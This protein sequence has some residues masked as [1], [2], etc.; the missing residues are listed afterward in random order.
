MI[1]VAVIIGLAFNVMA[2][3]IGMESAKCDRAEKICEESRAL[4]EVLL[5]KL[6]EIP[7]EECSWYI[8]TIDSER[9]LTNLFYNEYIKE[10]E[11]HS[12]CE[13][14]TWEE[15]DR[16]AQMSA[17]G[18]NHT[19]SNDGSNVQIKFSQPV[20]IVSNSHFGRIECSGS[21]KPTFSCNNTLIITDTF[22]QSD[23]RV[24]DVVYYKSS[25]D[26]SD[27]Y[28]DVEYVVHRVIGIQGS[29]Y[30][31]RGDV[32]GMEEIVPYLSIKYKVLG[33]IY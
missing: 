17:T 7:K 18:I 8:K 1:V 27:I 4:D 3:L 6:N 33:V 25:I 24:G 9:N 32:G 26:F 31:I 16:L 5:A 12:A 20:Q 30:T 2:F 11:K 28:P 15:K 13:A 14:S 19:E 21:M 10:I 22:E 29:N 23:I